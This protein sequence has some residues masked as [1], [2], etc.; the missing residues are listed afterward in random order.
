MMKPVALV[1]GL[2][3]LGKALAER[4]KPAAAPYWIVG[5]QTRPDALSP[6][7]P[8]RSSVPHLAPAIA[9]AHTVFHL[10]TLSTPALG[11]NNPF[12]DVEN[13][14]FTVSLINACE[15]EKIG[16]VVF[17]SSGGTVYGE[18]SRPRSEGD[19]TRPLCSHGLGKLTSEHF[20]HLFSRKTG[21]PV[22]VLR[23]GN[24]YGGNQK[25][26]GQQGVVGYVK[27]QLVAGRPVRLFG[28]TIRDYIHLDDFLDA[29]LRV[30]ESPGGFRVYNIGTG[31]GT[32]LAK[33]VELAAGILR[34]KPDVIMSDR[35][36]FDLACNVLNCAKAREELG[37]SAKIPLREGLEKSLRA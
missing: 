5:R 13:I 37:W 36:P 32:E 9:G 27:E 33:L 23:V 21:A 7:E 22:T 4:L 3:Y 18:S 17:I 26:K 1:G 16:H 14:H 19:D 28:N 8:Y 29:C 31:V 12:L 30:V 25:A 15:R 20:L 24:V 6:D 2:G 10:A 34:L 11:Y 35:R